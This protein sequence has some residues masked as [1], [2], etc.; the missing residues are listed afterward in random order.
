M[1][2]QAPPCPLC[3]RISLPDLLAEKDLAVAFRDAIPVN[4]GHALIVPRRH[5]EGL[6]DLF[7]DERAA[8]WCLLPVVKGRLDAPRPGWLQRRRQ[9]GGGRWT[10]GRARSRAPHS[11][12]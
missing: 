2:A 1:A 3:Q 5:V 9:R 4:P 7:P 10:D 11:Q 8:L 12:V 6:F